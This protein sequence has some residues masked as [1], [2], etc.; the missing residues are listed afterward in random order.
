MTVSG[1]AEIQ[2]KGVDVTL[3][4]TSLSER[5]ELLTDNALKIT[6]TATVKADFSGTAFGFIFDILDNKSIPMR[7]KIDD[8]NWVDYTIGGSYAHPQGYIVEQDLEDKDHTVIVEFLD[9]CNTV[10]GGLC[11]NGK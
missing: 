6:G 1:S 7:Y 8:G 2:T 11:V 3:F 9:G 5:G 4:G 10:L